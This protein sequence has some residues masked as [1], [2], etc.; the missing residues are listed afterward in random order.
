[1]G[2]LRLLFLGTGDYANTGARANQSIWIQSQDTN[3]LLECGPTTLLRM[4]QER[5]NPNELQAVLITHFHGDHF[6]GIVF[7]DLALTLD[8]NRQ[9]SIVYAGP[10]GLQNHFEQTYKVC[11][12]DFY[13]N[14]QFPRNFEEYSPKQTYNLE[15][16]QIFPIPMKHKK[17]SLGYRIQTQGKTIAFTGDTA[18]NDDMINLSKD[19]DLLITECVDYQKTSK[20]HLSYQE[21]KEHSALLGAKK[22]VLTHVGKDVLEN[23][24]SIQWDIMDDGKEILL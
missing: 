24:S 22:I 12:G 7:L 15:G 6:V 9:K 19:A 16:M 13:P 18:W 1:M 8:W 11:Y 4:Q 17:E 20:N 21:L 3:V 23:R 14:Y 10:R 2:S 5:L